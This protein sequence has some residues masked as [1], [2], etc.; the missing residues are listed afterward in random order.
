[1]RSSPRSPLGRVITGVHRC[2]L[3]IESPDFPD[4][5]VAAAT[6]HGDDVDGFDGDVAFPIAPSSFS[7]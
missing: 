5:C 7:G 1:M 4:G 6:T 2:V 3:R